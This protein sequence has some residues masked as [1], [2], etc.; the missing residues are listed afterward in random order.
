MIEQT[1]FILTLAQASGRGTLA[2]AWLVL[3]MAVVA[4][5][6]VGG[7]MRAVAR[8][9]MP[10]SR[11]RIRTANGWLMLLLIPLLAYGFGLATPAD[12]GV[13]V[14]VWLAAIALLWMVVMLAAIDILNSWRLGRRER[15]SLRAEI[16]AARAMLKQKIERDLASQ[17]AAEA[18]SESEPPR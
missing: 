10:A 7:H 5:V 8:S 12:K 13:F 4:L 1:S 6:A 2:P 14:L 16:L 17:N 15:E 18:R 11:K 3:P 9:T